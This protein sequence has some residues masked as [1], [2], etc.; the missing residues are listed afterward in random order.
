[1]E[2]KKRVLI[3]EDEFIIALYI[4]KVLEKKG[5]DVVGVFDTGEGV[6]EKI[7]ELTPDVLLVDIMLE[8]EMTGIETV[9]K[10]NEIIEVCVIYLTSN[11]N[12]SIREEAKKTYPM[13]F[14]KKP[15]D[16]ELL[17]NTIDFSLN[18]QE[19]LEKA[20]KKLHKKN[21][22]YKMQ[23][24]ELSETTQHLATATLRERDIK[25]QLKSTIDALEDSRIIITEQN[26]SISAI[27]YAKRIQ[28]AII[29]NIEEVRREIPNTDWFYRSKGIVSGDFPY[30]RK[31]EHLLYY[32]AVDCTGHGVPGAMMSL[33]G[34][35]LLN[36]I[37]SDSEDYSPSQVLSEL[38]R[39]VVSSLKQDRMGNRTSDGMDVA[40]CCY[41]TITKKLTYSGAHRPLYQVRT[42]E[43]VIQYKGGRYP[44]GG[45]QHKSEHVYPNYDVE[46]I[47][48]DRVYLFSDGFPD[49]FGGD[50]NLKFG[51]KRMRRLLEENSDKTISENITLFSTEFDAWMGANNQTDDVLLIG[52]EFD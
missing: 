51:A 17:T 52:I 12:K 10:I 37:L 25:N 7:E 20:T 22:R 30:F 28:E 2:E 32:A 1:M 49:Q 6:L 13:A 14:L 39:G 33:I 24:D 31:K 16:E 11:S 34:Y 47:T 45:T 38:H 15:L 18:L 41:N 4:E 46:I 23:L 42:G 44:I 21:K 8:G 29:P 9:H 48:G 36:D 26:K 19:E 35:L 40:I 27:N 5:Y 43:Q 50:E 3:I